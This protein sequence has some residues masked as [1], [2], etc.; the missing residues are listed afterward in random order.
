MFRKSYAQVFDG[1]V[2][3]SGLEIPDGRSL[4]LGR[5][6]TYVRNPPYF[7]GMQLEPSPVEDILGARVLAKLG[8]SV[9][10]DHISPAG[11][12]KKDSPAGH[13]LM[14]FGVGGG[15]ADADALRHKAAATAGGRAGGRAGGPESMMRDVHGVDPKDFNSY[16]SRRGN[17]EVMVRGTFANIRLR[18]LL[19]P[20]PRARDA[21]LPR[22]E[23]MSIYD[24][25]LCATRRR[26]P[27]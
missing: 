23:E 9:T 13:Y 15:D 1:D 22:G 8:D 19:R 2:N 21:A 24:A 25:A 20:G 17:H 26:A 5:A 3:W 12:L 27:R 18:N 7:E 14:N 16:G 4:R 11:A 6:A 10:T